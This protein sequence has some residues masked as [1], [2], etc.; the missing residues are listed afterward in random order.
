[1]SSCAAGRVPAGGGTGS[2]PGCET[3]APAFTPSLATDIGM[4]PP[5]VGGDPAKVRS[6]ATGPFQGLIEPAREGALEEVRPGD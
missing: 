2:S 1:M 4:L 3:C 6:T 5:R